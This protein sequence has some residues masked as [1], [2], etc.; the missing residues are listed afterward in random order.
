MYRSVLFC[1]L[2]IFFIQSCREKIEGTGFDEPA[3]PQPVLPEAWGS[4][5]SGFHAAFGTIDD[6]YEHHLPPPHD[7]LPAWEGAAWRGERINIQLMLWS[8]E[9]IE[10]I[11]VKEFE[12]KGPGKERITKENIGI[13]PVRYVITD[14]FLSGCGRRDKDTIPSY[15]AADM[16]EHNQAFN[17]KEKT[18]RPVWI[19][20]DVPSHV[21][22]GSY[23]GDIK[24]SRWGGRTQKLP[25]TLEVHDMLLPP[26]HE[27]S[28]HLD[29]W[30]NPFAVARWHDVELWSEEHLEL[31][32]PYL[33]M[34]AAAGQKCITA[35]IL[36][37]PWGG[38]TFD[39]FESMIQ[40]T[41]LGDNE[42]E[43]DYTIFDRWVELA[44]E[45]GITGQINCYSMVPWGNHVRYFDNDS[46]DYVTVRVSPGSEEYASVWEPFL[47]QFRDHLKEKGWLDKTTIAMDERG[48]NDMESMID[49]LKRV[50][51][52]FQIALAGKYHEDISD[53]L[54]DLCVFHQPEL[55]KEIIQIRRDK[56]LIT[57]FYT[58]CA[59]PE[60]PNNFTFSPPAEQALL[61]WYAAARGF[62]GFL[63]WAYNSWVEDPVRDSRFRTWPAGDTY[64]VYPG[65]RS[66]I[67]FER[68]R[69]G[70]QDYE[71]IAVVRSLLAS[72]GDS[73]G[74]KEL[75]K[76][77]DH[78][79][80]E[81]ITEPRAAYWV[82]RGRSLLDKQ[83]RQIFK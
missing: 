40:W 78:F 44:M 11:E 83:S 64:Q 81:N 16:L 74:L 53:D 15:L 8:G 14:L 42:W 10:N 37:R 72:G 36:H 35:S 41:H 52:E 33:Q 39:H 28:F 73:D 50:A 69:E 71:K 31:L 26:P 66:S 3:N 19:T 5:A 60:H 38:Q 49:L 46:A 27:W 75:E 55:E 22:A 76:M 7:P 24:V 59:R 25:L 29:L 1:L 77:L 30:Q 17:L 34:L 47:M 80:S 61:G 23:A 9:T 58:M 13:F 20:I 63:R 56:G 82:N 68:L 18:L 12:L 45:A 21:S 57:T 65:P 51:P 6:R 54:K 79:H 70:I 4:V 48:L 67:R 62:N 2:V 32:T 43:Y